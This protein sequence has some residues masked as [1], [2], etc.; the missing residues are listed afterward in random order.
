M[1]ER[2]REEARNAGLWNGWLCPIVELL[3]YGTLF[4]IFV[5]LYFAAFGD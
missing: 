3:G 1:T 4:I 2:Q 5:I